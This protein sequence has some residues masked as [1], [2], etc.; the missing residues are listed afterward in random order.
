MYEEFSII[1]KKKRAMAPWIQRQIDKFNGS[2]KRRISET[3]SG[4][5]MVGQYETI[6]QKAVHD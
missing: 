5:G 2:I 3:S 6:L 4:F 1:A